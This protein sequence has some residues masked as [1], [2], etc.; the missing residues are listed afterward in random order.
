MVISKM[1]IEQENAK[2]NPKWIYNFLV[3]KYDLLHNKMVL[4]ITLFLAASR[5]LYFLMFSELETLFPPKYFHGITFSFDIKSSC[6]EK[7]V[8]I[9]FD[10]EKLFTYVPA[11]KTN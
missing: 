11:T 2:R 5:V 8:L 3:Q 1:F 4:K 7:K 10:S 9:F 6:S